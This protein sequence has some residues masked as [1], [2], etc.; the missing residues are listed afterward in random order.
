M[1]RLCLGSVLVLTM[2][3]AI[4]AVA[5]G[6]ASAGFQAASYPAELEGEDE[7]FALTVDGSTATCETAVA[8]GTLSAA[9]STVTLHPTFSGCAAFGFLSAAIETEGCD[10]RLRS[11]ESSEGTLDLTCEPVSRITIA[12]S[13]CEVQI[14][15]QGGLESVLYAN[16]TAPNP[17]EIL[18]EAESSG[19]VATVTKD[20]FLCPL[21]GVGE[22]SAS[23]TMGLTLRAG[24]DLAVE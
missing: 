12:A 5:P 7:S 20:G 14:G 24:S 2:L 17:D 21:K 11:G 19:L 3:C 10:Y 4:A 9:S 13:T 1:K 8:S 18:V 6:L 22:K 23:L 16:Q 15:N